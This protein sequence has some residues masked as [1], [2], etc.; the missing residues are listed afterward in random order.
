MNSLL[1]TSLLTLT[2]ILA[3]SQFAVASPQDRMNAALTD[4]EKLERAKT[5][6]V[7][8]V[9][10][11]DLEA[12]ERQK[13]IEKLN[14]SLARVGEGFRP[15]DYGDFHW[16]EFPVSAGSKFTNSQL[17]PFLNDHPK[18]TDRVKA[19]ISSKDDA[20]KTAMASWFVACIDADLVL[21]HRQREQLAELVADLCFTDSSLRLISVSRAT[22]IGIE[23]ILI[24]DRLPNEKIGEVLGNQRQQLWERMLNGLD[25]PEPTIIDH[26]DSDA[27]WNRMII[28]G[29]EISNSKAMEEMKLQLSLQSKFLKQPDE[30][31]AVLE[32][33]MTV[34]MNEVSRA[35]TKRLLDGFEKMSHVPDSTSTIQHPTF[36]SWYWAQPAY[37]EALKNNLTENELNQ[38]KSWGVRRK[39]FIENSTVELIVAAI[40]AELMLSDEQRLE[41]AKVVK[42]SLPNDRHLDIADDFREFRLVAETIRNISDQSLPELSQPQTSSWKCFRR[43]MKSSGQTIAV[44]LGQPTV[45]QVWTGPPIRKTRTSEQK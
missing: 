26:N 15:N 38:L 41:F 43:Q 2:S 36:S 29:T 23:R 21:E 31:H 10:A 1:I 40:D 27:E 9:S 22:S 13:V 19:L 39:E 20:L 42:A 30:K 8:V 11:C 6:A 7:A 17:K 28:A 5:Y 33:E 18:L 25:Q 16:F 12:Q 37:R 14:L 44:C 3:T 24:T 45:C 4:E 32:K 34:A 35:Y